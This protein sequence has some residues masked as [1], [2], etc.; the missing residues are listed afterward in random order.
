MKKKKGKKTRKNTKG[1]LKTACGGCLSP[2]Y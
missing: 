1:I 2:H